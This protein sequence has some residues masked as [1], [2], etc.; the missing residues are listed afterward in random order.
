[1][2]GGGGDRQL[3]HQVSNHQ[4]PILALVYWLYTHNVHNNMKHWRNTFLHTSYNLLYNI[5]TYGFK[6]KWY[7]IVSQQLKM[8]TYSMNK[9]YMKGVQK[10][11]MAYLLM[12]CK[13]AIAMSLYCSMARARDKVSTVQQHKK[14][15]LRMGFWDWR[16][17]HTDKPILFGEYLCIVF[18]QCHLVKL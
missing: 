17:H 12:E 1:M 5:P 16:W 4:G 9:Q 15:R 7:T 14:K 10:R 3:F 8:F 2:K 11:K 13:M 18:L 6:K